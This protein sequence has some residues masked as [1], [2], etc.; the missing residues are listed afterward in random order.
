MAKRML[1]LAKRYKD[2]EDSSDLCETF[3]GV[4]YSINTETFI[5]RK[6]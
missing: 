2:S 6:Q 4:G 3:L 5:E 1:D